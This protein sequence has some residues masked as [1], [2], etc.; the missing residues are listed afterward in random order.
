MSR[1]KS[2]GISRNPSRLLALLFGINNYCSLPQELLRLL[3]L[4]LCRFGCLFAIAPHHYHAEETAD[5]G[6]AQK[7]DDDWDSDGPDAGREEGLYGVRV[8]DEGLEEEY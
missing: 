2:I 5:H 7:Q 8:V 1:K 4:G 3:L 6:S